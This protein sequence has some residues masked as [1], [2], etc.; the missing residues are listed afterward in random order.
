MNISDLDRPKYCNKYTITALFN[1]TDIPLISLQTDSP[2]IQITNLTSNATYNITATV[3]HSNHE[4]TN[5]V[6][7]GKVLTLPIETLAKGYDPRRVDVENRTNFQISES[8][9]KTLDTFIY[10][11]PSDDRTCNYFV[12]FFDI[13]GKSIDIP[14][15]SISIVSIKN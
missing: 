15:K 1:L 11:V 10:W 12:T 8:S 9:N 14:S 4:Y 3:M 7:M 5:A 13:R 2:L 6:K